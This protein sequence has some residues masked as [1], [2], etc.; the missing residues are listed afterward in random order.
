MEVGR[1]RIHFAGGAVRILS[2][3][4]EFVAGSQLLDFGV[5]EA[6][7]LERTRWFESVEEKARIRFVGAEEPEEE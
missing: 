6:A 4:V 7:H 3:E 5:A 1:F 2:V